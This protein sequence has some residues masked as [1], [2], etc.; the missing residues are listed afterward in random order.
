[1]TTVIP[2]SGYTFF[3]WWS[4]HQIRPSKRQ[5]SLPWL[6]NFTVPLNSTNI[7]KKVKRW[8][9]EG[10]LC[11]S[12]P[13]SITCRGWQLM[14]SVGSSSECHSQLVTGLLKLNQTSVLFGFTMLE[15]VYWRVICAPRDRTEPKLSL[16][17]SN[18][19]KKKAK[20]IWKCG[21]K[22]LIWGLLLLPYGSPTQLWCL[23]L[24]D[25]YLMF[26]LWCLCFCEL[27]LCMG[28]LVVP[29]SLWL[30]LSKSFIASINCRSV[31]D[32][33]FLRAC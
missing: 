8:R 5:N 12:L 14:N 19:G 9:S 24:Y 17:L 31:F 29:V 16:K 21:I 11:Y 1:M 20:T 10:G 22:V 18:F 32:I 25:V 15:I 26:F 23:C 4:Q 33:K 30:I 13:C 6:T 27:S 7:T 28:T 3:L 2:R